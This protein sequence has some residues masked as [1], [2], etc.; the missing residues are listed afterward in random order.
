MYI[1]GDSHGRIL[2]DAIRHRLEGNT[3]TLFYDIRENKFDSQSITIDQLNLT[4]VWDSKGQEFLDWSNDPCGGPVEDS[5]VLVVSIA[6]H[7]AVESTTAYFMSQLNRILTGFSACPYH[8]SSLDQNVPNPQRKL[9][10]LFAPAV[11]PRWDEWP[12]Q[13]N[14]H[15][16]NI[17]MQYWRDLSRKLAKEMGW[18]FVDQYELTLPHN[19]EPRHNDMAHYLATDAIDPIIDEVLGKSGLCD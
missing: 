18:M 5:D 16:T 17:R 11:V 14:D 7:Y 12:A 19:F 6:A 4:Y 2:Y 9:I 15:R 3:D 13:F 8:P 1:T 10:F